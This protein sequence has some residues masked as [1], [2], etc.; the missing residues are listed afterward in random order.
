M[1]Y[2]PYCS[3]F[4]L[5]F[6]L[7]FILSEKNNFLQEWSK[8]IIL[9]FH[10]PSCSIILNSSCQFLLTLHGKQNQ[11]HLWPPH[12]VLI[13][14]SNLRLFSIS[15]AM[16][17]KMPNHHLR[18]W[19]CGTV[20]LLYIILYIVEVDDDVITI[21]IGMAKFSFLSASL[22]SFFPRIFF[23][24]SELRGRVFVLFGVLSLL[25]FHVWSSTV[26]KSISCV[27]WRG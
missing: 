23:M 22:R 19:T 8:V 4:R 16:A 17:R 7:S 10:F 21:S 27:S 14:H 12:R 11:H 5:T 2:F 26:K 1:F 9:M 24:L 18:M 6:L 13:P 3:I 25:S 15:Q 20:F